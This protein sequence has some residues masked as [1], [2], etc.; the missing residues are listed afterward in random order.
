[1]R[2]SLPVFI[3]PKV[4]TKPM[5]SW[6]AARTPQGAL[7]LNLT[8]NG[9]AHIQIKEFKLSLPG[10]EQPWVTQQSFEYVLPG[11]SRELIMPENLESPAPPSGTALQLIAQTDAG[12]IKAEVMIAP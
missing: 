3:L 5:L 10:K 6:Q 2:V 1:M 9:N 12:I 8:N 4:E 7:K 11:Q